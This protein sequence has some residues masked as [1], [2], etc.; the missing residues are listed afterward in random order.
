MLLIYTMLPFLGVPFV[1]IFST[2]LVTMGLTIWMALSVL[3]NG[4]PSDST[5]DEKWYDN[6]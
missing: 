1:I 4:T 3:K 2:L 6:P 5:F